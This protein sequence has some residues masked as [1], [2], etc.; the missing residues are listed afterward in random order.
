MKECKS[1]RV[2]IPVG[3]KSSADQYPKTHEE[4]EDMYHVPYARAV[5]S[6]LYAMVCTRPYITHVVGIVSRYMSKP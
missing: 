2:P 3:V 4:E 1:V 5:C 6:L